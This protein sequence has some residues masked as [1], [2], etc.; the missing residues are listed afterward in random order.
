MDVERRGACIYVAYQVSEG[1]EEEASE[2]DERKNVDLLPV[3]F[4]W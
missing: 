2:G 1:G 3:C 4:A